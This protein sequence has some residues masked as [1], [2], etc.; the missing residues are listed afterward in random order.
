LLPHSQP[1]DSAGIVGMYS[2]I[3]VQP[4]TGPD[5]PPVHDVE[6]VMGFIEGVRGA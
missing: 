3:V 6:A 4:P 5:V 2:L 1:N